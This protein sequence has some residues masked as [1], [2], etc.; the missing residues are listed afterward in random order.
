MTRGEA[1]LEAV[2]A[3]AKGI[4]VSTCKVGGSSSSSKLQ[5]NQAPGRAILTRLRRNSALHYAAHQ[6]E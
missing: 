3:V 5:E 2:F 1:M 6:N 4:K